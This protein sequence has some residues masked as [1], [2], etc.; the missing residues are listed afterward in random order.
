MTVEKKTYSVEEAA[1]VV[2]ISARYMYDL[3]RTEGFPVIRI[4]RR[5]LIPI[6]GLNRW[7]EEQ[8]EKGYS[9]VCSNDSQGNG[10]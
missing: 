9:G 2:G 6:T 8:A 7:L 5:L 3:V 4:G 10:C 1:Q